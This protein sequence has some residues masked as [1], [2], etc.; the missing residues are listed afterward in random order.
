LQGHTTVSYK[1]GPIAREFLF[2]SVLVR[3]AVF[4]DW[5][6]GCA[7]PQRLFR[8]RR[9]EALSHAETL[10]IGERRHLEPIHIPILIS[11][12]IRRPRSAS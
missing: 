5:R 8:S 6:D 9:R 12:P 7:L 4:N 11:T 1:N 10:A 2:D 3:I